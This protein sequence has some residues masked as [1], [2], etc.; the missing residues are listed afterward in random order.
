M[1]KV[2]QIFFQLTMILALIG[3][4]TMVCTQRSNVM[5]IV[6]IE[7]ESKSSQKSLSELFEV[8]MTQDQSP[9]PSI[10]F[11][12]FEEKGLIGFQWSIYLVRTLDVFCPPP[13][14]L[15]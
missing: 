2:K 5:S 1:D 7:E 4:G 12:S 8:I 14:V 9:L 15:S 11:V 10:T 6:E 13:E 3:L